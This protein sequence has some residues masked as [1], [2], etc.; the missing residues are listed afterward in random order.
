MQIVMK[1]SG[2]LPVLVLLLAAVSSS[3]AKYGGGS[4][5]ADDPY[6]IWTAEQMNTIGANKDD[7]GERFKLMADIDLS[8]FDGQ[9]GRPAF[10]MIAPGSQNTFTGV[11]DGNGHTISQL[12]IRGGDYLGL[13]GQ[14]KY[15]A[16]IKNLGL[17][18]IDVTGSGY[19]VS[20]VGGLVG[21]NGTYLGS[22]KGGTITNCYGTGMVLG[23]GGQAN[24]FGGLVGANYGE[25]S[26]CY[27][28]GV[29]KGAW[30]VGGLVGGNG[31]F[32]FPQG[33]VRYCYSTGTVQSINQ[34]V[35]GLVADNYGTVTCSYSNAAVS[36]DLQSAP[37]T[38][39]LVAAN[40]GTVTNCYS[41]GAVRGMGWYAGGLTCWSMGTVTNC[42]WDTQTSGQATSSGG[43][44]KTTAEMRRAS[45]FLAAG[46]DF[47]GETTNGTAE[48]SGGL[49]R[50]RAIP[51]CGGASRP[52]APMAAAAV[53][54]KTRTKSGPPTR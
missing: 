39:G 38:G 1:L 3:Q 11:F 42:F 46:W 52:K 34:V 28:T 51:N 49:M 4:G 2:C 18:D 27:Y 22:T 24:F 15:P 23:T 31:D 14:I 36:S 53:P 45:T 35:G 13:F 47:V 33:V 20:C 30:H 29:V 10:N 12:T 50:A 21:S 17:L 16:E 7:W 32:M 8:G 41:S 19:F 5:T 54:R 37:W 9:W 44:G 26:Q 25:V 40:H 43:T 48:T 6:Q